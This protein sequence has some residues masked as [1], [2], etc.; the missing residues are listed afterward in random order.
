MVANPNISRAA[1]AAA[2]MGLVLAAGRADAADDTV[3]PK[4]VS[5]SSEHCT[6]E[7]FV[8]RSKCMSRDIKAVVVLPPAYATEPATRYPVLYALHGMKAP[9]ASWSEMRPL[10]ESLR[11]RPMI[12]A[13]FDGDSD[14]WYVDATKRP[15][16]KFATFF[17]D[18]FIPYIESHYHTRSDSA[19]RGVTGF[20]MGG[21]GAFQYM[22]TRP[23]MFAS[24]SSLSGSFRAAEPRA[25]DVKGLLVPVL[26]RFEENKSEYAKY[27]I[28]HRLEEA[29]KHQ[30]PLPPMF[31]QCGCQDR[32]IVENRSLLRF[33]LEENEKSRKDDGAALLKFQYKESPGKHDWPYW[34]DA[35]ASIVDFH[36]RSFQTGGAAKVAPGSAAPGGTP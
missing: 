19:A 1:V 12:V 10:R 21:F 36:W 29:I 5:V 35:S 6:I 9:F 7:K 30:T 15:N 28:Y 23:E 4:E 13:T 25:G 34:R 32:L 31:F 3:V 24:V 27:A 14:G 18:E 17:F 16:S 11:D 33:F 26:G 8:V 22:L 2:L 20:S